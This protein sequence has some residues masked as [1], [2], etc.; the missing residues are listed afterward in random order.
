MDLSLSTVW[1]GESP[2]SKK[3]EGFAKDGITCEVHPFARIDVVNFSGDCFHTAYATEIGRR[4]FIYG[5][6]SI[7]GSVEWL[8]VPAP[9][10][11]TGVAWTENIFVPNLCWGDRRVYQRWDSATRSRPRFGGR[12]VPWRGAVA[13]RPNYVT[14]CLEND[15]ARARC[16]R[17]VCMRERRLAWDQALLRNLHFNGDEQG[18]WS[19]DSLD[20]LVDEQWI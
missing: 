14:R 7:N 2:K 17:G 19:E 16:F 5:W 9:S 13:L 3:F 18:N 15:R 12:S 1:E 6:K 8:V 20:G 11:G 10:C 4:V